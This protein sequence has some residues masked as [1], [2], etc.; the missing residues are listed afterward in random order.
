VNFGK[1]SVSAISICAA[2]AGDETTTVPGGSSGGADM[3]GCSTRLEE[4]GAGDE[5]RTRDRYLGK[6]GGHFR[7]D[8]NTRLPSTRLSRTHLRFPDPRETSHSNG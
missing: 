4:A 8:S 5:A 6:E 3:V 7:L 2:N 1:P